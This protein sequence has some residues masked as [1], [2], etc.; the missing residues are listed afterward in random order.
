MCCKQSAIQGISFAGCLSSLHVQLQ[1]ELGHRWELFLIEEGRIKR[2]R[3]LSWE[4]VSGVFII[5]LGCKSY[6]CT[7]RKETL[8]HNT[9][10]C[11][12]R[13]DAGSVNVIEIVIVGVVSKYTR[14][15]WINCLLFDT[16]PS[17]DKRS[18]LFLWCFFTR[19]VVSAEQLP[20]LRVIMLP[21]A[22][23]ELFMIAATKDSCRRSWS[24]PPASSGVVEWRCCKTKGKRIQ[25]QREKDPASTSIGISPRLE[26]AIAQV[27]GFWRFHKSAVKPGTWKLSA[28]FG[29]WCCCSWPSGWWINLWDEL[30]LLSRL[31]N[32]QTA[33]GDHTRH[34]PQT[35]FWLFIWFLTDL[36]KT[37]IISVPGLP[38]WWRWAAW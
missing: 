24:W 29:R 15:L 26:A 20:V 18:C 12:V 35:H 37:E 10:I 14:S 11:D 2:R 5:A 8:K 21:D 3:K 6:K 31:K 36:V 16:I 19:E 27:L 1:I 34:S 33:K 30:N 9:L 4:V 13:D 23:V 25:D 32:Y 22:N 28:G 17:K 38:D 7:E